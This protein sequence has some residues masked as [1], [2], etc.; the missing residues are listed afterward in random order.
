MAVAAAV[1][2]KAAGARAPSARAGSFDV[3]MLLAL[4]G[5]ALAA[6]IAA[7]GRWE[8]L[9]AAYL[10]PASGGAETGSGSSGASSGSSGDGR[11]GFD[12]PPDF[13]PTTP[14]PK[15]GTISE[16]YTS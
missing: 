5:F 4:V 12:A 13:Q 7:S 6:Y 14:P 9:K 10:P 2:G 1:I 11:S 15:P 16:G 3:P 8:R